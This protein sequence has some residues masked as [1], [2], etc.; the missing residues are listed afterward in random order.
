MDVARHRKQG[1]VAERTRCRV[2]APRDRRGQGVPRDRGGVED[3]VGYIQTGC[4]GVC[5][6][7]RCRHGHLEALAVRLMEEHL[8]HVEA[9]LVFDRT[10]PTHDITLALS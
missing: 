2:D 10:P 8:Q 6:L 9:H 3:E 7:G 1:E 4:R 5:A